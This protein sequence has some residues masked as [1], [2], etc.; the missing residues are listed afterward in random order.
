MLV[1]WLRHAVVRHR[2]R[3]AIYGA[4]NETLARECE[5]AGLG[6]PI[7]SH[8]ARAGPWRDFYVTWRL[9]GRLPAGVPV[10]FAPGAL[11]QSLLQWLAAFL[12]GRRVAG[13]VP[14]AYSSQRMRFR[15]GSLRDWVAGY[16]I[17]RVDVWITIS[18]QQREL[19]ER[20][21]QVAP[22][23]F[24]VPNRLALGRQEARKARV[25]ADGPLRVLYAGRFDANQKGLD[26]LCDRLRVRREDWAGKMRF[27]FKGQGAF[28]EE[29]MRLR[30]E[31]GA[32]RV[33]VAPWGDVASAMAQADVLLLPSRFE[34]LPLVALEATH[35][36]VPV[37]ASKDAGVSDLVPPWSLF[38]FG[39]EDAMWRALETLRD[40]ARRAEALAYSRERVRRSCS[41][42]T[43]RHELDRVIAAFAGLAGRRWASG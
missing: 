41:T 35:Y 15:G 37:V 23:V 1:E 8:P 6:R 4:G 2:L 40:P 12:R 20:Q 19:L 33:E 27:L 38:D 13:Y 14:M 36:G 18:K 21:W 17:R 22:P 42:A 11:Q 43:F 30:R 10:L 34:G 26:W 7:A 39:D 32:A 5:A 31:L 3:V 16:V 29:L 25:A 9:L 24:V 28:Q